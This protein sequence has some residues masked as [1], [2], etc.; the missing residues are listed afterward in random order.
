M[1]LYDAVKP[2]CLLKIICM[3][4]LI[5]IEFM[6]KSS[7][8]YALVRKR[9]SVITGYEVTILNQDLARLLYGYELLIFDNKGE[10]LSTAAEQ[11]VKELL[12]AMGN[13]LTAQI[14]R[15]GPAESQ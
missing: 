6:Y 14:R 10:L 7:T 11:K 13:A 4:N 5:S 9:Y 2:L 3:K 8:Y 1:K 12:T 15:Y